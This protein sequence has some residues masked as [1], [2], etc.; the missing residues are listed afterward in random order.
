MK[1]V[2]FDFNGTMFFDSEKHEQAWKQYGE[3][4]LNRKISDEEFKNHVH[5]RNNLCILS[6]F[7][8]REL[9]KEE[10]DIMGEEKEAIYR[11]LCLEDKDNF[12]LVDGLVEFLDYLK[13]N[14]YLIN[15]ATAS[16]IINV[17]FFFESFGLDKWFDFEKIVYGNGLIKSKPDPEIFL[18]AAQNLDINPQDCIVFEDSHSGL[19]SAK[20]ANI[21]RIIGVNNTEDENY[22][23][24]I[25]YLFD[26]IKNFKDF[27]H[28]IS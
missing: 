22:F 17:K 16:G 11:K 15:I 5:G 1:A 6:Y 25:N 26:V 8:E 9:S 3:M 18:K 7:K 10:V 14:K 13:E 28:L 2:I 24:N 20:N 12:K 27:K 21:A 4:V 19:G 23:D